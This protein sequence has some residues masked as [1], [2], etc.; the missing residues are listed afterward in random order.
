MK[1]FGEVVVEAGLVTQAQ[2]KM[3]LAEKK[4]SKKRLGELIVSMNIASEA[5]IAQALSSQLGYPFIELAKEKVCPEAIAIIDEV[6]AKQ[7]F[8]FP[9]AVDDNSVAGRDL[10][11]R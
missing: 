10:G 6:K 8:V 11:R 2:F 7:E 4:K 1:K 5:E 3:V 9:Y